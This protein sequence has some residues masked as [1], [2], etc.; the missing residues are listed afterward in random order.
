ME[1]AV[2]NIKTSSE[3]YFTQQCLCCNNTRRLPE[4]M[5]YCT[6]PWICDE[7][8]DAIALVKDFIAENCG[9]SKDCLEKETPNETIHPI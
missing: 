1:I 2:L 3:I 6:T 8:K 9:T 5:T 4:G 7:C